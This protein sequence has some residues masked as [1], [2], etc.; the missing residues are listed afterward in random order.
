MSV[1]VIGGVIAGLVGAK[2]MEEIFSS[3]E[4]EWEYG[5]LDILVWEVDLGTA[6]FVNGSEENIVIDLADN[7]DFSP[8]KNLARRKP[9]YKI[10]SID[11][12]I[13]THPDQDHIDDIKEFYDLCYKGEV[14]KNPI[15][16]VRPPDATKFVEYRRENVWQNR[17]QYVDKVNRYIDMDYAY[18]NY[19][20]G[21]DLQKHFFETD[22][23]I[24]FEF[25]SLTSS[26]LN[27]KEPKNYSNGGN[28]NN[29][30]VLTVMEFN[31]FKIVYPGD[32]ERKG[33]EEI[34]KYEEVT[35]S[36]Q[37]TDI[38]IASHHG[39][40]SGYYSELFDII[41]P[42]CTILSDGE[43]MGSSVPNKYRYQS[44]NGINVDGNKR[45]VLTTRNDKVL[46]INVNNGEFGVFRPQIDN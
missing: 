44:G 25:F 1:A 8:I 46:Q 21:S 3:S 32:L 2:I 41:E 35:T 38:L 31:G 17:E 7:G 30:S 18:N 43:D 42:N 27:M 26:H 20:K 34:L 12:L 5:N 9:S 33:F 6:I 24:N 16:F 19:M 28:I 40:D 29:L 23:N 22:G 45:N 13:I 36:I 39:R 10:N 11:R 37:N 14:F 4:G 15:T